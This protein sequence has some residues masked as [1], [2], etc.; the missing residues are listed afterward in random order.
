MKKS[1]MFI[2]TFMLA[3]FLAACGSS[4]DNT[5]DNPMDTEQNDD[6]EMEDN[7][8]VDDEKDTDDSAAMNKDDDTTSDAADKDAK[9]DELEFFE[10]QLEVEYTNGSQYEAEIDKESN[11]DYTAEVDDD[12]NNQHLKG[13]EAF[14]H[15]YPILEKLDIT[16]DSSKEEVIDQVL[17]SFELE[18]D[19]VE[20]EVEITFH[21]GTEM[22]YKDK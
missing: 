18:K 17:E 14:D 16:K 1:L 13:D 4:N 12:I 11:G 21:D 9:M 2:M 15:I 20:F 8:D 7:D 5:D 22:E 6:M 10:I 3:G 19:Y